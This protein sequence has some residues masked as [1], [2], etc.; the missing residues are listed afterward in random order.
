MN[1]TEAAKL[2][3]KAKSISECENIK[4]CQIRT[5]VEDIVQKIPDIITSHRLSY[6]NSKYIIVAPFDFTNS[7][8]KGA[9][10]FPDK[11]TQAL[12]DR[13]KL[14]GFKVCR[15]DISLCILDM[16]KKSN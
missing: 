7:I 8:L 3:A 13:L 1:S 2:F 16:D 14:M 10:R 15:Q 12:M 5:Y 6:Y 9:I 11:K 4:Q